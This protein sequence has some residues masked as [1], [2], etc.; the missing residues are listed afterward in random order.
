MRKKDV[1]VDCLTSRDALT[2]KPDSPHYQSVLNALFE[3]APKP[4][5]GFL[6]ETDPPEH[7]HLNEIV[8][9]KLADLFRLHGAINVEPTLF[10]PHMKLP[11]DDPNTVYMLDHHGEVIM[12]P[13]HGLIPFA[14]I[15]ART[16]VTRIKRYHIG[17]I[18]R[19]KY[20]LLLS[21]S[22]RFH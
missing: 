1:R 4:V 12:L 9:D 20:C 3:Q 13:T 22:I 7:A 2:A 11:V 8:I 6:Y 14:R 21:L 10:I 5:R 18:Y 17:D 19:N 16:G 15:A